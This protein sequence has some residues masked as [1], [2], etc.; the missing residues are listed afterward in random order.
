MHQGSGSATTLPAS[1]PL[2]LLVLAALVCWS[3]LATAA[4]AIAGPS[5]ILWNG[6]SPA[7]GASLQAPGGVVS[8]NAVGTSALQGPYRQMTVDGVP[9]A[10]RF[11][12]ATATT[13]TWRLVDQW[14]DDDEVWVAQ[15][16]WVPSADQTR[17]MLS[18]YVSNG[19]LGHDG[20]HTVVATIK[21]ANGVWSTDSWSFGV[22][23][24]PTFSAPVPAPGSRVDTLTPQISVPV[25]DNDAVTGWSAKVNGVPASATL[26]GGVL[27]IA[28][29]SA[30]PND[31]ISSV[32]VTIND[33][34][35]NSSH[36]AW[37]FDVLA[38]PVM[39]DLAGDCISCHPG[40]DT[41]NDMDAQCLGCHPAHSGTPTQM[42]SRA[43]DTCRPCHA[44]SLPDEH[45]R[46][47]G[48]NGQAIT[49]LTCHASG[50]PAV[51]NAIQTGS[52]NCGGCHDAANPHSGID[53]TAVHT[54]A[55]TA[56]N[57]TIQGQDFGSHPPITAARAPHA[58]RR[59]PTRRRRGT[60]RA[61]AWAAT[62]L[63]RRLR[64]TPRWTRATRGRR[65]PTRASRAAATTPRRSPRLRAGASPPTTPTPRRLSPA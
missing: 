54:A 47:V 10:S 37:S 14:N 43:D 16:C 32:D 4:V 31:A 57:F 35:G 7:P 60:G 51:I 20:T 39:L 23:I 9:W 46:W 27:H 3:L 28:L 49:C 55:L 1:R 33:A 2:R 65:S 21:D 15:W 40:L 50:N 29:A 34:D 48:K 42:H 24:K 6:E 26:S 45:A 56:A 53:I 30:L 44:T 12:N 58:T 63:P 22:H 13:G 59:P 61:R 52:S 25:A 36:L 18:T 38:Y 8:V 5:T 64:C 41:D 19:S 17:A 62:P 11:T